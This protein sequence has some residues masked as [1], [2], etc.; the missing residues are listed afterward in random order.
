[1][2]QRWSRWDW[3]VAIVLLLILAVLVWLSWDDPPFK[4]TNENF[5]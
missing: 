1:M 4:W 5:R 3:A 2:R